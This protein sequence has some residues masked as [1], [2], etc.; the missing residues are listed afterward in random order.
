MSSSLTPLVSTTGLCIH[1]IFYFSLPRSLLT[2]TFHPLFSPTTTLLPSHPICQ[3]TPEVAAC[4]S[5]GGRDVGSGEAGEMAEE[6]EPQLVTPLVIETTRPLCAPLQQDLD[7]SVY[8]SS[9]AAC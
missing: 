2:P 4:R 7:V 8:L 1:I 9:T 6:A 5:G 3:E